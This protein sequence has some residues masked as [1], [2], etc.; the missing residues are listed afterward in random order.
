MAQQQ[1]TLSR[2]K[3]ILVVRSVDDRMAADRYAVTPRHV[4]GQQLI[5]VHFR[6]GYDRNSLTLLTMFEDLKTAV[7]FCLIEHE[8]K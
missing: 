5:T 3:N 2:L 8:R 4:Q 6:P 7:R 1:S